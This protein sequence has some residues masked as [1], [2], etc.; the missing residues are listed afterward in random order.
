M[1][2]EALPT[3]AKALP[4]APKKSLTLPFM[5]RSDR[6]FLLGFVHE[7]QKASIKI[8]AFPFTRYGTIEAV[9]TRIASDAIPL[10]EAMA[11]E[12]NTQPQPQDSKGSAGAQRVQNLYFP[13][14]LKLSQST[15]FTEGKSVP[16]APGMAITA[17]I[18]TEQRRLLDYLLSPLKKVGST[19]VKER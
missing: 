7:G 5:T 6:E 15:I 1:T 2:D 9:V 10:P 14:T 3:T 11:A 12:G 8:E 16:L 18:K 19:A 13:V 4:G 17:E